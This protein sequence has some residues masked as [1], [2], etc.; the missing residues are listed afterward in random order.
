[1]E[2]KL[3]NFRR[4]KPWPGVLKK[5]WSD[6]KWQMSQS[7][8]TREDFE[9]YFNLSKEEKLGFRGL[10]KIFRV[11]ATPYY[12]SLAKLKKPSCPVRQMIIPRQT[13]NA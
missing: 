4:I 2:K 6:W 3:F 7:L 10:D 1:M 8:K 5:Y 9:K 13:T 12:V 11:R